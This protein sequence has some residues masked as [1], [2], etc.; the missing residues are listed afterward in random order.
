MSA[1]PAAQLLPLV[2][3]L[4][5]TLVGTILSIWLMHHLL[6]PLFSCVSAIENFQGGKVIIALPEDHH[7]EIGYLMRQLNR[8]MQITSYEISRYQT[9]AELDPLTDVLNRRG[10]ERA[11]VGK[12]N[13]VILHFDIDN[14]KAINDA[15]GHDFGDNVLKAIVERVKAN[16]RGTDLFAR[17]G[18]EEFVI[19]SQVSV[20]NAELWAKRLLQTVNS[21]PCFGSNV[22]LSIGI[23]TYDGNLGDSIAA[24]DQATYVA[25]VAGKNQY[26]VADQKVEV[27]PEN[28]TVG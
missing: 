22:T 1:M 2:L 7:D 3:V 26:A 8:F 5:A 13:G 10:L 6:K 27:V 4:S 12:Q 20:G 15:H 28:W 21:Q 14:F 23:A 24:G 16:L 19:Y 9:E 18:G 17:V 11:M 25:K